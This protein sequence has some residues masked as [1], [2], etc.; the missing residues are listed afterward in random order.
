MAGSVRSGNIITLD[1]GVQKELSIKIVGLSPDGYLRTITIPKCTATGA[2]SMPYKK[3]EKT[4]VPA[5]FQALKGTAD[6]CTIVDNA[7]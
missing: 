3:G 4:V 2:V 1:G 7:A 6:V 5:T